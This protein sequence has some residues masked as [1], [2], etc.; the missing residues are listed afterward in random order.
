MN[1]APRRRANIIDGFTFFYTLEISYGCEVE[2][3]EY[4]SCGE[5]GKAI[6]CYGSCFAIV[7]EKEAYHTAWEDDEG[8]RD[9][10][11]AAEGRQKCQSLGVDHPPAVARTVVE[12]AYD[13]LGHWAMALPIMNTHGQ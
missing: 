5:Y 9:D 2:Y 6:D 4:Q 11:A 3:K 13:G 8:E 1:T 7:G 10:C 12:P